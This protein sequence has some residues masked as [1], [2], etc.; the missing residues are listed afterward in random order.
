MTLSEQVQPESAARV[1]WDVFFVGEYGF[2]EH[3]QVIANTSKPII[4]GR[5]QLL[6]WLKTTGAKPQPRDIPFPS[7]TT[8][9]AVTAGAKTDPMYAAAQQV[10]GAQV[11]RMCPIHSADM[12]RI[13]G[14]ADHGRLSKNG[15]PYNAFW[16]CSAVEGCRGGE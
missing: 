8:A 3:L 10:L 4:E 11:G 7:K 12:K 15:K 5:A 14:T 6:E 9:P 2:G 1:S 13:G 16:V